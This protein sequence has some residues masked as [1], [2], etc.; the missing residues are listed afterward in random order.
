MD[1]KQIVQGVGEQYLKIPGTVISGVSCLY[2]WKDTIYKYV[3]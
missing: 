2:D 1:I 3:A